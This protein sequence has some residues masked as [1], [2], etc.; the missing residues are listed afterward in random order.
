M[1]GGEGGRWVFFPSCCVAR[2]TLSSLA[3]SAIGPRSEKSMAFSATGETLRRDPRPIARSSV[4]FPNSRLVVQ[5]G[6]AWLGSAPLRSARLDSTRLGL[7]RLGS[8]RLVKRW[9]RSQRFGTRSKR[10]RIIT[11]RNHT[12][13]KQQR[14]PAQIMVGC[15][16]RRG[17]GCGDCRYEARG[18]RRSSAVAYARLSF[19]LCRSPSPSLSRFLS[20]SLARS[21]CPFRRRRCVK[22]PRTA[23]YACRTRLLV[24]IRGTGQAGARCDVACVRRVNK[25]SRWPLHARRG[26]QWATRKARCPVPSLLLPSP[27]PVETAFFRS[28]CGRLPLAQPLLPPRSLRDAVCARKRA[29]RPTRRLG[30][31]RGDAP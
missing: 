16:E 27:L 24:F 7:A 13:V 30:A 29:A 17:G 11:F 18:C 31:R 22:L 19:S 1:A 5:L 12:L 21:L 20:R 25:C 9:A 26:Q 2:A 8:A 28:V 4:R 15:V 10:A 14:W 23:L 3:K 6:L